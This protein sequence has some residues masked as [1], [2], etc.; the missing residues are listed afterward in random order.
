MNSSPHLYRFLLLLHH[1]HLLF[2]ILNFR[3]KQ[4]LESLMVQSLFQLKKKMVL[5]DL[6][7]VGLHFQHQFCC[8][9][10]FQHCF[11][12]R[13][14]FSRLM[15]S[16]NRFKK[17]SGIQITFSFTLDQQEHYRIELSQNLFQLQLRLSEIHGL[18]LVLKLKSSILMEFMLLQHLRG[19]HLFFKGYFSSRYNSINPFL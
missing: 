13:C 19:V 4:P 6:G 8:L 15:E 12:V 3:K 14:F 16:K 2:E 17:I 1:L 5:E 9:N 11:F 10:Q 18:F 7:L